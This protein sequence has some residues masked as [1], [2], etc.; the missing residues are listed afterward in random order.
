M[1]KLKPFTPGKPTEFS[2]VA[3]TAKVPGQTVEILDVRPI[4][5]PNVEYIGSIAVWPNEAK[6]NTSDGGPGFPPATVERYHPALGVVIP[7][8]ATGYLYPGE[9][10]PRDLVV[11]AGFRLTGAE[12]GAVNSIEVVYRVN[13]EV[14]RERSRIG[15]VACVD[16]CAEQE[17]YSSAI[18]WQRQLFARNGIE[19]SE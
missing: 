11:N 7:A 4:T 1:F 16:P 10:K 14:R 9:S 5:T 3:L 15:V 6:G 12:S 2:L 18:D 19:E 17:T 13:G 8:S